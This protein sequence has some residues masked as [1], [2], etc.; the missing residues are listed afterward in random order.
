MF[1]KSL[2]KDLIWMLIL[3]FVVVI[4]NI[5]ANL[6]GHEWHTI[7]F[8]LEIAAVLVLMLGLIIKRAVSGAYKKKED[9]EE[10]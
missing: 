2:K 10:E 9:D 4:L 7:M 3:I 5:A 6:A 8:V 1:R